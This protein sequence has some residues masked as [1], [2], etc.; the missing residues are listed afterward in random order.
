M[1]QDNQSDDSQVQSADNLQEKR[2]KIMEKVRSDAK[3]MLEEAY[4]AGVEKDYAEIEIETDAGTWTLKR[5][6]GKKK[7]K[8]L[9]FENGVDIY[10]I[11]QYDP[12]P[13]KKFLK[14]VKDYDNFV[15][16]F[17]DWLDRQE[18]DLDEAMDIINDAEVGN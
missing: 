15:A 4:K 14:A 13:V 1:S 10:V 18:A 3:Q 5:E 12:A 11:S 7:I 2:E 16:G 17:N 6:D 8:Y 9:R